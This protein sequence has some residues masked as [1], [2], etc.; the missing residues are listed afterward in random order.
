M[1]PTYSSLKTVSEL[2]GCRCDPSCEA[3]TEGAKAIDAAREVV[4]AT[5]RLDP[6]VLGYVRE[7][8]LGSVPSVV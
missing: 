8:L 4:K 2:R 6:I 3:C 5:K 1:I 7:V